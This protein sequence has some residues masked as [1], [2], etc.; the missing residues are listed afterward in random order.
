MRT[1]DLKRIERLLLRERARTLHSLEQLRSQVEAESWTEGGDPPAFPFHP[2]DH[3]I[4]AAVREQALA[5]AGQEGRYFE[6]IE[7]A[8]ERLH[9]DPDTFGH[10]QAC[11]REV[12][13]E[14]LEVVPHT[15]YC[16]DC[17]AR[18]GEAA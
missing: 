3:G 13:L 1:T 12:P 2:A 15:R 16:L 17:K 6:R 9:R 4:E 14:R 5:I 7:A 10:C 8:L 18:V 11:G